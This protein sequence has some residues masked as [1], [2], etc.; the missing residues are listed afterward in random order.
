M[1]ERNAAM[2]YTVAAFFVSIFYIKYKNTLDE[3]RESC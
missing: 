1:E 2:A 3:R